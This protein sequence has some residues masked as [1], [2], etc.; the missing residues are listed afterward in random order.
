MTKKEEGIANEFLSLFP[1]LAVKGNSLFDG[2][3]EVFYTCS[4]GCYK[5][6]QYDFLKKAILNEYKLPNFEFDVC[7]SLAKKVDDSIYIPNGRI[8]EYEYI[9]YSTVINK[10]FEDLKPKILK[11]WCWEGNPHELLFTFEFKNFQVAAYDDDGQYSVVCGKIPKNYYG[12]ETKNEY[13]K[14]SLIE[15]LDEIF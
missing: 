3:T 9:A 13:H 15:D 1:G 5:Y 14:C 4:N 6:I 7:I 8:D 11:A 12:N 10:D 2:D